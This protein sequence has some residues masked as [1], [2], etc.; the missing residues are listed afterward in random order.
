MVAPHLWQREKLDFYFLLYVYTDVC[1]VIRAMCILF[2][3]ELLN[4][5]DGM[6]LLLLLTIIR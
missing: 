5:H 2:S 6:I 3:D 4:N 1:V